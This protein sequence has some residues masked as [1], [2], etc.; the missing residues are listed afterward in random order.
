MV[1][2]RKSRK[3]QREPIEPFLRSK[4]LSSIVEQSAEDGSTSES[5]VNQRLDDEVEM[6]LRGKVE[7]RAKVKVEK[8]DNYARLILD[9]L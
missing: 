2:D 5:D 3:R 6:L 4:R 7:K 1:E 8:S 9:M